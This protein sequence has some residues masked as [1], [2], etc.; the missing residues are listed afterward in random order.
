MLFQQFAIDFILLTGEK[1]W[2]LELAEAHTGVCTAQN[3]MAPQNM[4]FSRLVIISKGKEIWW[5]FLLIATQMG[6]N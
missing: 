4:V 5:L 1:L 3:T 6:L 2:I